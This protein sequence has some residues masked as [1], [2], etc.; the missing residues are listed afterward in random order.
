M[1]TR[2]RSIQ[3]ATMLLVIDNNCASKGVTDNSVFVIDLQLAN[4]RLLAC[5]ANELW[6]LALMSV[7]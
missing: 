6:A 1:E 2:P 5:N 3:Q 7:S 4:W